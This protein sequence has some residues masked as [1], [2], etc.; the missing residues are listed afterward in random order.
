MG[1]PSFQTSAKGPPLPK[2]PNEPRSV[3]PSDQ[4]SSA[5]PNFTGSAST[6]MRKRASRASPVAT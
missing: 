1:E 5:S 3:H 6:V 2:N 4:W